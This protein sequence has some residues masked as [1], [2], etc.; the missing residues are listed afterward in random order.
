MLSTYSQSSHSPL[1]QIVHERKHVV[2]ES[3][4]MTAPCSSENGSTLSRI[5]AGQLLHVIHMLVNRS[6]PDSRSTTSDDYNYRQARK[7]MPLSS[8]VV[9]LSLRNARITPAL[10]AYFL[11]FCPKLK[12][13][14]YT[15]VPDSTTLI[16]P[17]SKAKKNSII[18]ADVLEKLV[19][20]DN[21]RDASHYAYLLGSRQ[22]LLVGAFRASIAPLRRIP[23][24]ESTSM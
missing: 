19:Y 23:I 2:T 14:E 21:I 1:E 18:Y 11:S 10:I 20:R 17:I 7:L 13:L 24:E 15:Q 16:P 5:R 9:D 6:H 22:A 3:R 12:A 8:N 4:R